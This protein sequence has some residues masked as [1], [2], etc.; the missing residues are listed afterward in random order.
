MRNPVPITAPRGVHTRIYARSQ[1][2]MP[3]KFLWP[4]KTRLPRGRKN[5]SRG[6]R[7]R[8]REIFSRKTRYFHESSSIELVHRGETFRHA[9]TNAEIFLTL[10]RPL[11]TRVCVYGIFLQNI[12][13]PFVY[14]FPPPPFPSLLFRETQ[15]VLSFSF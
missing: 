3:S 7:E 14:P 6:E 4:I 9:W 13:L 12:Q 5:I 11:P 15:S 2:T 10:P 8:E 1:K